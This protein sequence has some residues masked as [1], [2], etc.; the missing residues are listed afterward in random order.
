MFKDKVVLVLGGTG[1]I[2]SAIAEL[3]EREH[4]IVYKHSF[5]QG[6]FR[7][8]LSKNGEAEQLIG[9][10]FKKSKRIDILVNSISA[11]T[12]PHNFE[13]IRWDDFLSHLNVQLRAA[14][15]VE[16]LVV[17]YMK[18]QGGGRIISVLSSYTVG[19]IPARF[20]DYVTAKYA[21]LGLTRALSKELAPF[22]ITVNAVSPSFIRNRFTHD[23]PEKYDELLKTQ[24]PRGRLA[25]PLDV[26]QCVLY[27]ASDAADFITGAN[28]EIT[29][30]ST[31]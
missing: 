4:A 10:V 9:A 14:V 17:P 2:G 6:A 21:L 16:K 24:T 27:L 29:G 8:D 3:F 7:A 13:D 12:I 22:G 19:H 28:I 31:L 20:S 26:A 30:G 15:D 1:S 5:S 23:V 11:K 18:R 25:E